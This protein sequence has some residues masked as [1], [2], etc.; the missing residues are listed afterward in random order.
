MGDVIDFLNTSVT[1]AQKTGDVLTVTYGSDKANYQLAGPQA[2][3]AF[4]LQSD[5]HGGTDLILTPVVGV[6]HS[7]AGHH[8]IA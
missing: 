2:N 3:T 8:M 6:L 1:G 7:D 5:G 4:N